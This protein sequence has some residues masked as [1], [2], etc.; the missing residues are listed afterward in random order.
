MTM[1]HRLES[2]VL[3]LVLALVLARPAS[4]QP[5]APAAAPP[6]APAAAGVAAQ[7]DAYLQAQSRV[8]GFSGAVLI[9]NC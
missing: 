8:N 2:S 5:S 1:R 7:A 6:D 4:A 3:L 9:W